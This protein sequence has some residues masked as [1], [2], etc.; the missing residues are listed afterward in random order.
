MATINYRYF[1]RGNWPG[2]A[3]EKLAV[4]G[5]KFLQTLD[6]LSVIDP[7]FSDWQLHRNWEI[8]DDEQPRCVSLA[9]A[10]NRIPEIVESGVARDDFD[11][12]TPAYGY[13]V[14]ARAGARGP[15]C[16]T[17][18]ARTG[19]QFFDLSF[20]E[21]NVASD[22]TIV[23]YPLFKAALLAISTACNAPWAYAQACRNGIVK[24]PVDFG[25][26]IPAFRIDSAIPVPLDP[27]FPKSIFHVPWIIHLSAPRA[28]GLKL[29]PEIITERTA[30]GGLLMS[31]TTER[32][33]PTNPEHVKRARILAETLIACTG[34]QPGGTTLV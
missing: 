18:T 19:N 6:S 16:V 13:S 34:Y 12:P 28:A 27:T 24:V 8:A 17:F 32:L 23:T 22:L 7:L 20:G 21:H 31:A 14:A 26:G 9:T 10:R 11:E 30:D 25:P 5:A 33:D 4:T 1:V 29:T 2:P 15:R 3:D